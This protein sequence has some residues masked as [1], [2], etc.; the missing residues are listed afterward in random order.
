MACH[1]FEL[2]EIKHIWAEGEKKYAEAVEVN[3]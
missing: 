2:L 3:I 1:T